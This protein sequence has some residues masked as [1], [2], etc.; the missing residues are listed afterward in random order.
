MFEDF[1]LSQFDVKEDGPLVLQEWQGDKSLWYIQPENN[2]N[3]DFVFRYEGKEFAVECKWRQSL[4]RDLNKDLF[5]EKRLESYRKFSQIRSMP[6]TIILGVGGEPCCPN[7]LYRIPLES[8]S[9]VVSGKRSIVD[10]L[11][12]S[13]EMDVSM[14]LS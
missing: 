11:Q 8:I 12:P 5:P 14:F 13:H 1:V 10:F 7:V 4:S 2:S 6:V 3:P 9:S